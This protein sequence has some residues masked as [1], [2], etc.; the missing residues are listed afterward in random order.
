MGLRQEVAELKDRF[1]NLQH[2]V[3]VLEINERAMRA[4]IDRKVKIAAC[5]M[6][7]GHKALLCSSASEEHLC[8][9]CNNCGPWY[10]KPRAEAT[11]R[12]LRLARQMLYANK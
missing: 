12:E 11:P 1:F 9:R 2:R 10:H 3:C 5:E 6:A 4:Q 7:T 8:F